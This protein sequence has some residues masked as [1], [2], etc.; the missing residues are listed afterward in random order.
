MHSYY[1]NRLKVVKGHLPVSVYTNEHFQ[2]L[3]HWHTEI[4]IAW[5]ESG[6]I[7][8][9][10][11]QEIREMRTGD[12]CFCKSGDIHYY[13][14]KDIDSKVTIV[15]CRVDLVEGLYDW[16]ESIEV[17][18]HFM[19]HEEVTRYQ[20]RQLYDWIQAMKQEEVEKSIGYLEKMKAYGTLMCIDLMRRWPIQAVQTNTFQKGDGSKK[21]LQKILLYIEQNIEQDLS[22][23]ELAKRYKMDP[24][25]LSKLFNAITGMHFKAYINT[26]RVILAEEKLIQTD[27]PIIEIAYACGFNSI[28]NFNRAFKTIKGKTPREIRGKTGG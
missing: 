6:T 8:M 26:A 7:V 17:L 20:L 10:I 28:R 9:G 14:S 4:E 15:V 22:L 25:Y 13:E 2:Y 19:T 5:V 24:Y 21:L 3:A 18:A 23:E 12:L 27:Q 1:E 11:N 16:L